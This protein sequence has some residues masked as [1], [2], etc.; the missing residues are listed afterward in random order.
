MLFIKS[1]NC[2]YIEEINHK[3]CEEKLKSKDCSNFYS[4]FYGQ[5]FVNENFL[6]EKGKIPISGNHEFSS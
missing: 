6:R 5:T 2:E 3:N 4:L 1:E